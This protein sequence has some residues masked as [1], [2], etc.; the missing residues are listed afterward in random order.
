[1]SSKHHTNPAHDNDEGACGTEIWNDI[2]KS[3]E[4]ADKTVLSDVPDYAGGT[5]TNYKIR[6]TVS[7]I[8]M[9]NH[10]VHT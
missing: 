9:P 4:T 6:S 7:H 3:M 1:M 8:I 5:C 2:S 10:Y